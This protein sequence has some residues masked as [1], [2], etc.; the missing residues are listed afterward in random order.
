MNTIRA[1]LLKC[2]RMLLLSIDSLQKSK[3]MQVFYNTADKYL[4]IKTIIIRIL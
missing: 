3:P 2:Q 4:K 1:K